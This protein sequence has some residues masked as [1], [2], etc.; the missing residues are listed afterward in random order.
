MLR[1]VEQGFKHGYPEIKRD[2]FEA[3]KVLI[4][5]FTLDLGEY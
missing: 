2:S 4:D 1:I 3:W 5:N